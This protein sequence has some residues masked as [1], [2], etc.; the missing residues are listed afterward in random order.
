MADLNVLQAELAATEKA[1]QEAQKIKRE[2]FMASMKA[3]QEAKAAA[4]AAKTPEQKAV[5]LQAK[6]DERKAHLARL[7]IK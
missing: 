4:E 1:I 2:S 6:I 3:E 7:K 5:E